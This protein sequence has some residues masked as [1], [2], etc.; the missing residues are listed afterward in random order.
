MLSKKNLGLFFLLILPVFIIGISSY[1]AIKN[2]NTEKLHEQRKSTA[3]LSAKVLKEKFDRLRDLGVS[4]SRRVLFMKM[5]DEGNW[6]DAIQYVENVPHDF[7]FIERIGLS[8]T[9][10]N[11]MAGIPSS[12]NITGKNFA[13]RDWFKGVSKT[14]MPYLSQV[15]KR[16]YSPYEVVTSLATPVKNSSG[17]TIAYLLL[18]ANVAKLLDWSKSINVGTAGNVFVVDQ[19]GRIG[20]DINSSLLD[21]II[22]YSSVPSVQKALKGESKVE[23]LY[24]PIDKK[25]Y[26]SAYEQIPN[27]GWAV[28]VQEEETAVLLQSVSHSFMFFLI[29]I[30]IGAILFALYIIQQIT[31][32]EKAEKNLELIN[33][34]LHDSMA[35][36]KESEKKFE[37]IFE[38]MPVGITISNLAT[39]K[40]VDVNQSFLNMYG[41]TKEDVVGHHSADLNLIDVV[42][43]E[44]IKEQFLETKKLHN[45][46]ITAT[47]KSGEKIDVLISLD[48][49]TYKGIVYA[50]TIAHD[51]S[52]RKKAEDELKQ[53]YQF[54]DAIVENIPNML[55]VKDAEEL[56][57]VRFNKAGE[58]LLGYD[59]N[60]LIGKNDYDFFPKEQAEFFISKDKQVLLNGGATD[61]IEEPIETKTGL[62][63]LHTRKIPLKD[64]KGKATYLIGISEDITEKRKQQDKIQQLNK[65]LQKNIEQLEIVN[66]EIEAFSYSVSHD[67]RAPLRAID[68]YAKIIEEDYSA[69]FNEEG[70][71]LLSVIQYNATKMGTLIDD[72]LAFSRLG[73]KELKKVIID[74]EEL[75]NAALFDIEKIKKHNAVITIQKLHSIGADYTLMTQ[76]FIN[77]IS[78]AIKY[79]SKKEQQIIEIS[80]TITDNVVTYCVADNGVGFNMKYVHKLFGVFQRLHTMEEFE[81]TGVGLA[82]VQRIINKH[83]GRIWAEAE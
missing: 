54:V 16:A 60:D 13:Y 58:S 28:I 66:K 35:L 22:D 17:K 48:H 50:V 21:T 26:L 25:K 38:A 10:G 83:G 9:L 30:F 59:R 47:K 37:K 33:K 31:K 70:K 64:N 79:S 65:E 44:K 15:Y 6:D 56:R 32:R 40:F 29:T 81:G 24:N 18:Q 62:K 7:A 27:Y 72:L 68:G 77:L 82:I 2:T 1:I 75:A 23:V 43:I 46:E 67:L 78:N 73:K 34:D 51:I 53:A 57:F 76:V 39:N 63:W 55:F 12:P 41:F 3:S 42:E 5:I 71:R 45:L 11:S 61:I 4:L 19:A 74:M 36:L 49:F 80:S 14:Q 20:G 69:S 8:D 52:E